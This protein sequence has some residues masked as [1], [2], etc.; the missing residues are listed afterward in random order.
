MAKAHY[1]YQTAKYQAF[2]LAVLLD[3]AAAVHG[4]GG[5]VYRIGFEV[6]AVHGLGVL[7]YGE[8]GH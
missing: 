6:A 4:L 5:S 3:A 1:K 8:T 2:F 7:V